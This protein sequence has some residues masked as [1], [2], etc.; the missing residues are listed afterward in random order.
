MNTTS[1]AIQIPPAD[2]VRARL[3]ELVREASVL[4]R[5]LRVAESAER[6]GGKAQASDAKAKA[7]PHAR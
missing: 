2:E 3:T 5:L 6:Q 7:V 1:P 4:R